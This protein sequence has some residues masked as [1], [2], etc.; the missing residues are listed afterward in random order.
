M[1]KLFLSLSGLALIMLT[2]SC[3]SGGQSNTAVTAS[4]SASVAELNLE[5]TLDINNTHSYISWKGF[6][7]G[8]EH[9]GKLPITT[10]QI[11][12]K[13]GELNAGYISIA[14]NGIIVE[15][16]TGEM[17]TQLKVHL[18][19][20]DF[21]DVG[22]YPDARF[23]LTGVTNTADENSISGNLTLKDV[24]KNINIPIAKI[25]R[26]EEGVVKIISQTFRINRTDWNVKYG[27][28]SIFAS[29]GDN[30]IDDEIELSFHLEAK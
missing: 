1:K 8:G 26:T 16:L 10:G 15:D 27:S 30:F 6:K 22:K 20:Q 17:A 11:S 21:F 18:E 19:N 2:T 23:E 5:E 28:K 4:D 13:G 29:L 25:E 24:T 9:F 7:P 3:G 12:F 14:M